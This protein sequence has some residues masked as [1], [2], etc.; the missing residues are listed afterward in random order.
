MKQ[1]TLKNH[2]NWYV[3]WYPHCL[4]L[5]ALFFCCAALPGQSIDFTETS[6]ELISRRADAEDK[7]F[8]VYFEADWCAPCQLMD[9]QTFQYPPLV[10]FVQDGML[11][12]RVDMDNPMRQT[13]IRRFTVEKIPTILVFGPNGRLLERIETALEGPDLLTRLRVFDTPAA[14]QRVAATDG[15]ELMTAPRPQ[16]QFSRPALIPEPQ[17]VMEEPLLAAAGPGYSM[18]PRQASVRYGVR[19]GRIREYR[20]AI[21]RAHYLQEKYG[22]PVNVFFEQANQFMS[23]PHYT[24]IAGSYNDRGEAEDLLYYL[25]RND[26]IGEVTEYPR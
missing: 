18:V 7:L 4:L 25:N 11:A 22:Y 5:S 21:A 10:R 19:L 9:Q 26:L 13:L 2:G 17:P 16:L 15:S 8:F 14:H 6:F 12:L 3:R 20:D 1:M 24:V 23:V